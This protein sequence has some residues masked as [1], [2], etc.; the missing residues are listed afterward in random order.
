EKLPGEPIIIARVTGH[1]DTQELIDVFRETAEFAREIDGQVYRIT[2]IYDFE[3]TFDEV[4][5]R[6]KLSSQPIPG[7]TSD[8]NITVVLVGND[9]WL[10][11]F[12][13]GMRHEQYGGIDI[14]SFDDM[15]SALAHVR[16]L[17]NMERR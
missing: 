10:K 13:D 5:E 3:A 8:P 1:I 17:I 6:V 12:R 9:H 4:T 15:E 2:H 14:P 11:M 7:S 16:F